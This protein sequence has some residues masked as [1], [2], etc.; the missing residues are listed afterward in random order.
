MSGPAPAAGGR[1]RVA[2][3]SL[4]GTIASIPSGALGVSPGLHG[5]DLVAAVPQLRAVAGVDVRS[6]L[7]VPGAH[8]TVEDLVALAGL[9][10]EAHDAGAAGVVVTQGTDTIEDTAFLLDVL[11]HGPMPV[12]VT[13]A[14]RN[15]TLP[16]ADGPANLLAAV[17][18]AADPAARGLGTLV[19][20]NDE[21]HAARFVRK[22]HASNPGA[23]RSHPGAIGWIAE[24]RSYVALRPIGRLRLP[25][26]APDA[27]HRV[28]TVTLSAGDDGTLIAAADA[29]GVDGL[30]VEAL[31]GGHVPPTVLDRL[32]I[33]ARRA[34]VVVTSTTRAGDVLRSTYNFPGSELD[35]AARG[36]LN[37]AH[38]DARK[39]GLLL[40]LLLRIGADRSRIAATFADPWRDDGGFGG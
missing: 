15:P 33:A 36:V 13:G 1:P 30:I 17:T 11:V 10:D 39:A 4:G 32:E 24:G 22:Q 12:V 19:V 29:T 26:P 7:Q 18:V 21:I 34:P 9:V 23:F 16:G 14:M 27:R 37:G 28:A 40:T 38:F 8:L 31:G 5:S 2:V 25:R 20:L 3:L 35:L 6:V